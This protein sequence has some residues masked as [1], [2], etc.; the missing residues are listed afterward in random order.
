MSPQYKKFRDMLREAGMSVQTIGEIK[1]D[2]IA[3]HRDGKPPVLAFV[4]DKGEDGY[5]LYVLAPGI[6]I[7]DD[8]HRMAIEA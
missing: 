1:G 3:V 7:Q 8:V 5:S 2:L 6:Q 4:N